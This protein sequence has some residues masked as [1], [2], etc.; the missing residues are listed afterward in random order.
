M[1]RLLTATGGSSTNSGNSEGLAAAWKWGS[2]ASLFAADTN[3]R[4]QESKK[5]KKKKKYKSHTGPK[6]TV[7]T[8]KI[9]LVGAALRQMREQERF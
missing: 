6:K 1:T 5:K 2:C 4:V 7:K 8:L 3:G 9:V